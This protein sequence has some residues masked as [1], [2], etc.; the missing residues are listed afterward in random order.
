MLYFQK[1]TTLHL[2]TSAY[3]YTFTMVIKFEDFKFRLTKIMITKI[4]VSINFQYLVQ[5]TG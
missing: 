2:N 3:I 4:R 5:L 1:I